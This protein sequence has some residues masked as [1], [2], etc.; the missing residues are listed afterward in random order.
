MGIAVGVGVF[1]LIVLVACCCLYRR[2][3]KQI[4]EYK[5]IYFLQQSDYKV[6]L[7]F[8]FNVCSLSSDGHLF[9]FSKS[10]VATCTCIYVYQTIEY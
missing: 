2:Q 10:V 9:S 3:K 5:K 4:D 7:Y 6:I 8:L 1:V